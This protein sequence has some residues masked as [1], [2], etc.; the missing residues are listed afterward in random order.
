MST[1]GIPTKVINCETLFPVSLRELFEKNER[2]EYIK[3]DSK[4]ERDNTKNL[5]Y[6]IPAHQRM[7]KWNNKNRDLLIESVFYGFPM[8]E[9]ILSEYV[10]DGVIKYNIEDGQ[11]RLSILQ[12]YHNDEFKCFDKKFN[13]L[14]QFEKDRFLSY[15]IPRSVLRKCDGISNEEHEANIHEVFE[16]LQGGKPLNDAD[17]LW[18]RND[19]SVVIFAKELI[20]EYKTD[21]N[22]FNNKNFGEKTRGIL[23]EFVGIIY[24]LLNFENLNNKEYWTAYRFQHKFVNTHNI[25]DD[26]KHLVREFLNY[27]QDIIEKANNLGLTIDK[28]KKINYQKCNKLWGVV[29][30]DYM[31][32][33]EDNSDMWIEFI[34]IMRVSDNLFNNLWNGLNKGDRQNTTKEGITKRLERIKEFCEDKE[35]TAEKYNIEW[36]DYNKYI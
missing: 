33:Q 21:K 11:T 19:K 28:E 3:F 22:Y 10:I 29:L 7:P 27:Y 13:E 8:S 35:L 14:N 24:S 9:I 15:K 17:K 30:L 4:K 1:E 12:Q 34:K 5:E 36:E 26:E 25:T 31:D 16:R 23:P 18:N 6:N 2:N 20:E 32:N